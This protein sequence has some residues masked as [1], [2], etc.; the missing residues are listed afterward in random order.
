MHIRP[1]TFN[2]KIAVEQTLHVSILHGVGVL[3][4]RGER[5]PYT[6]QTVSLHGAN[7][8]PV[9]VRGEG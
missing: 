3:P 9:R 2:L 5:L 6:E 8:F 1:K 7:G 4:T